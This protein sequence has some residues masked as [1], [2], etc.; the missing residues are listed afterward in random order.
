M[1]LVHTTH[2]LRN[3]QNTV[4][5]GKKKGDKGKK[6]KSEDGLPPPPNLEDYREGAREA[7]LTFK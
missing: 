5:M 3:Q 6:E 2:A 1:G 7:L 4:N